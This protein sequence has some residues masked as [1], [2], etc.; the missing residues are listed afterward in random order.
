MMSRP[1]A[2][3]ALVLFAAGCSATPLADSDQSIRTLVEEHYHAWCFLDPPG[4]YSKAEVETDAP[5]SKW[6]LGSCFDSLPKCEMFRAHLLWRA[7]FGKRFTGGT[8]PGLP[9]TLEQQVR[10]SRQSA[11][12]S[13]CVSLEDS[14]LRDNESLMRYL[15]Q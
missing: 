15:Q 11:D 8:Y 1:A 3:L 4:D 13:I 9:I 14:R 12:A 10:M 5:F 7:W 2:A 6:L